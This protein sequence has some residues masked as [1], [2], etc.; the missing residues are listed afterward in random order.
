[1]PVCTGSVTSV[2]LDDRRAPAAR[3]AHAQ[4]A[5]IGG[6]SSSGRPSGSTTRPSSA[7]ADRHPHHL[8]GAAHDVAGLDGVR[9]RRAG[10]SRSRRASRVWRKAELPPVEAQQLVQ[11]HVAADPRSRRCR[12]RP[13]STRPICAS[14]GSSR[15]AS[16]P[17]AAPASSQVFGFSDIVLVLVQFASDALEIGLPGVADQHC[18]RVQ[19][20]SGDQGRIVWKTRGRRPGPSTRPSMS[21]HAVC[22]RSIERYGGDYDE[23]AASGSHECGAPRSG[24]L[25][26]LPSS[27]IRAVP[28]SLSQPAAGAAADLQ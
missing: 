17:R 27:A 14:S 5:V 21:R 2:A 26:Q 6:P 8:A 23:Q 13:S 10:R 28:R 9:R 18:G 16:D 11:P 3:S 25:G 12:R 20:H 15:T 22:R 19:F 24:N 4:S 7:V 1:M